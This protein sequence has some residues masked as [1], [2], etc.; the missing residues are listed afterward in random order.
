MTAPKQ[1]FRKY[2]VP[3][4]TD[5]PVKIEMG[6]IQL[7]GK[8]NHRGVEVG[9]GLF[10]HYRELMRLLWPDHDDHRWADIVLEQILENKILGILGPGNSG[11]TFS[12][13]RFALADY[14]TFPN[15]TCV[16]ISST[17]TR[18]LE[19][20]VWGSMKRMFNEALAR[21]SFLAGFITDSKYRITTDKV[22][23]KKAR[24][25]RKG[26][27]CIPCLSGGTFV[28]LKN[29]IGI[30][31]DRVRLLADECQVMGPSFLDALSNLLG[32]ADFKGVFMGNPTDPADPLGRACEP[33]DGWGNHPEPTKTTVWQTRFLGGRCLNLVGTDSPNFDVPEDQPIPFPNII[34]RRKL[35]E[36]K[37]FWGDDSAEYF[38]QC[39]GVMKTGLLARRVITSD[40][41]RQH[42]A[43]DAIQWLDTNRTKIH[44][45]DAAYSGVGGDRCVQGHVEFGLSSDRVPTIAVH[46]P[47][48]IPISVNI[49]K[50]PEDQIADAVKAYLDAQQIPT[51]NSFYD[52]TGRGTLGF[53]YASV[54]GQTIP[55]PVEFGGKPSERP[56][57]HD[58]YI[59]DEITGEKRL[60]TCREHYLDFVTE[61]WFS[62]RYVIET[63]QM[64][65]LPQAVMEEGSSREYGK[66]KANRI[67][68]ESKHDPRARARMHRS[69]DLFDW[70]A[71]AVEGCRQ[72]GFQIRRIV[73]E[74]SEQ[75]PQ[76][77][78]LTTMLKN[79]QRLLTNR[80]LTPIN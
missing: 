37:S 39:V 21:H 70:L 31:Q 69:P 59:T 34:N 64:R 10:H 36:V 12:A 66:G 80:Q 42:K 22:D 6:C 46:E 75:Q 43:Q 77:S 20:R 76:T 11:K 15:N 13:S 52:S 68:I 27:I 28:G 18:G 44:A 57:R 24:D 47:T 41:C 79:K 14:W 9:Q 38:S 60:Q 17:D 35:E 19:L 74:T 61:L 56:V 50:K 51:K 32:N 78:W 3:W 16:L 62:V 23:E 67:F 5:H 45:L 49:G 4:P 1:S 65:G 25:I 72:R 71:T 26:I 8:W 55:N 33:R 30:K 63:G 58:L 73:A 40:L 53:S 7:G 54:F 2:G 29:Y 48:I